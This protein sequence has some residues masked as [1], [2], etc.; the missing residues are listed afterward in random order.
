MCH[1]DSEEWK[2]RADS[3][4]KNEFNDISSRNLQLF[5]HRE[6]AYPFVESD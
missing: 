3:T 6:S 4:G 2:Y 5:E 1:S